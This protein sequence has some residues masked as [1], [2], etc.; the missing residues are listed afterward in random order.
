MASKSFNGGVPLSVTRIVTGKLPGEEGVQLKTP[1]DPLIVAPD[2]APGSSEN[3]KTFAGTSVSVAVAVNV[4]GEPTAHAALFPIAASTGAT[5]T[6]FTAIVIP[7]TALS[8]GLPLSTTW[9]V[10]E[11]EPGPW[12]SV[13]VQLNAPVVPL[14]VAPVAAGAPR[15]SK[16]VRVWPASGYV[17]VAVKVNGASSFTALLPIGSSTGGRLDPPDPM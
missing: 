15:K 12:A 8:C 2:G 4:K 10:M 9:T 11:Y 3:V 7:S 1:V 5:F 16:K 13:G 17:A 14:R 6:S